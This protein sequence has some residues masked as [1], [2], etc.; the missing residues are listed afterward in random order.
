[1]TEPFWQRLIETSPG[2]SPF[3]L[4][5]GHT[6]PPPNRDSCPASRPAR[7]DRGLVDAIPTCRPASPALP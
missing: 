1:M 5:A 3:T 4:R 6:E 2:R 7:L